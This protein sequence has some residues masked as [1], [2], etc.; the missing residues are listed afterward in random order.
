MTLQPAAIDCIFICSLNNL[1][2]S[3]KIPSGGWQGK[4]KNSQNIFQMGKYPKE[5]LHNNTFFWLTFRNT[6]MC[7]FSPYSKGG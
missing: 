2:S 1:K 5:N 3:D 7:V 4:L 6:G